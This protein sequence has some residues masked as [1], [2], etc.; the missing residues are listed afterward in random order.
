M[1]MD[2][3]AE[4]FLMWLHGGEWFKKTELY[5]G[6]MFCEIKSKITKKVIEMVIAGNELATTNQGDDV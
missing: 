4:E 1:D 5:A 3:D 2:I 6:V